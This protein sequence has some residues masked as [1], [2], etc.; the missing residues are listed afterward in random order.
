MD[1]DFLVRATLVGIVVLTV[2]LAVRF[3]LFILRDI[4]RAVE[5]RVLSKPAWAL[6]TILSIPIGGLLWLA[7]GRAR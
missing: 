4:Q 6:L 3:E 1:M 2:A 7:Y 5:V